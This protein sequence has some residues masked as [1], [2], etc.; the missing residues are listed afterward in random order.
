MVY[1]ENYFILRLSIYL[2]KTGDPVFATYYV[3][4]QPLNHLSPRHSQR[5]EANVPPPGEL[6][7][8]AVFHSIP[9]RIVLRRS[10]RRSTPMHA[11]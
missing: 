2:S 7:H 8:Q 4:E 5:H 10:G 6:D 9:L 11:F 1:D 3:Q